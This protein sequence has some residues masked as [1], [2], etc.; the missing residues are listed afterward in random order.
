[1]QNKVH[2]WRISKKHIL[3]NFVFKLNWK[4]VLLESHIALSSLI[5][6]VLKKQNLIMLLLTFYNKIYVKLNF[7]VLGRLKSLKLS[8]A[9]WANQQSHIFIVKLWKWQKIYQIT[10]RRSEKYFVFGWETI[11]MVKQLPFT[12][13]G[14]ND[15][16]PFL[17]VCAILFTGH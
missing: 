14:G 12:N 6:I 9:D 3:N 2:Y 11:L 10:V 7:Q 17:H 8:L 16:S 4:S 1:M 5:F 13:I 15:L